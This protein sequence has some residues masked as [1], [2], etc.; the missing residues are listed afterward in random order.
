MVPNGLNQRKAFFRHLSVIH[1]LQATPLVNHTNT[2]QTNLLGRQMMEQLTVTPTQQS[3]KRLFEIQE[4]ERLNTQLLATHMR[5]IKRQCSLF[6]VQCTTR[7][8]T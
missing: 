5:T 6:K 7:E 8:P 3:F 1:A 2:M 4:L